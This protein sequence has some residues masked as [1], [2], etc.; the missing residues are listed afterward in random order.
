M[1]SVVSRL[2]VT[3]ALLGS[4]VSSIEA[5]DDVAS[6]FRARHQGSLEGVRRIIE[7]FAEFGDHDVVEQDRKAQAGVRGFAGRF[8]R[9]LAADMARLEF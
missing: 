2:G 4:L 7:A 3:V 1:T 6:L 8:V 5:R 9:A